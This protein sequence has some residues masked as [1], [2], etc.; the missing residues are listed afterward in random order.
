[1]DVTKNASGGKRPC[2]G[3]AE[4]GGKREGMTERMSRSN[5]PGRMAAV[6][7]LHLQERLW[8]EAKRSSRERGSRCDEP[9]RLTCSR[10][11]GSTK[12]LLERPSV[13]RMLEIGMHGLKGGPVSALAA[14]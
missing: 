10:R 14:T 6:K 9:T 11:N 1:M 2:F 13:S 3:H 4:G 7:A 5:H 8:A 12:P